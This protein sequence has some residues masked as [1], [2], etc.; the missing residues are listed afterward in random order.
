MI[1]DN[2]R[3]FVEQLTVGLRHL[4]A[5]FGDRLTGALALGADEIG[6]AARFAFLVRLPGHPLQTEDALNQVGQDRQLFRYRLESYQSWRSRIQNA[7]EHYEQAGT[8]IQILRAIN[9]WGLAIFPSTWTVGQT[10]LLET[11][12][13]TFQIYI[14]SGLVAWQAPIVYGAGDTY[15]QDN[16]LYGVSNA[17]TEDVATLS[18]IVRKWKP[19]RS[20]GVIFVALGGLLYGE[21]GIEYG[22]GSLY[23]GS[24]ISLGV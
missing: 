18:R 20:Q 22:D 3:R 12:W 2:Y 6:E 8:P 21:P 5:H 24:T 1:I 23:G 14:S 10:F 11:G 16:L 7:W 19:A 4:R 15:G 9:D 13:A 17:D